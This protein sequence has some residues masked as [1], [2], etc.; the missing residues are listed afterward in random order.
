MRAVLGMRRRSMA[1][2]SPA[3]MMGA[4]CLL[5]FLFAVSSTVQDAFVAKGEGGGSD[6]DP[7]SFWCCSMVKTKSNDVLLFQCSSERSRSLR[8]QPDRDHRSLRWRYHD[9]P[10]LRQ[11]SNLVEAERCAYPAG[12]AGKI[13]YGGQ[14]VYSPR[15]GENGTMFLFA[16]PAYLHSHGMSPVGHN[17][18]S[19]TVFTKSTD[20]GHTWSPL[21]QLPGGVATRGGV[22]RPAAPYSPKALTQAA[23]SYLASPTPS[24][25]HRSTQRTPL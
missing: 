21:Q 5:S 9:G 10:Q 13:N 17:G 2:C 22:E 11:W 25:E 8:R 12:P 7:L 19:A 18:S 15:A 14:A 20:N 16:T 4:T 6:Q 23:S 3:T 1:Y 24:R